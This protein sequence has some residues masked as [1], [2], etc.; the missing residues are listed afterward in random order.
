MRPLTSYAKFQ[1][2]ASRVQR[3]R[4]AQLRSD[5]VTRLDYLDVGCGLNIHPELINLDYFWRPGVDVCWDLRRG[6]PFADGRMR[7]IFSEHCLEHFDLETGFEI[8][9]ECHRVLGVGGTLRVIVPDAGQYLA[10][11]TARA[12]GNSEPRFPFESSLVFRG[13]SAHLLHVN[14]V[15]YQDRSSAA[16]HRCMYDNELVSLLLGEAGFQTVRRVGFREGMD[17]VLLVDTE[18][19]A[20]ESLYVEATR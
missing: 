16:G 20:V 13:Q 3:N 5:R 2:L 9:R 6:L 12:T 17:P 18:A 19:R 8:L 15:F 4:R 14:R 1:A 10:T 11:Y 7:G